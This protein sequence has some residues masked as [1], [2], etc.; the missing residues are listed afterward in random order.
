MKPVV[1]KHHQHK[2]NGPARSLSGSRQML[3]TAL[4]F[5][6][7]STL[8]TGAWAAQHQQFLALG[9]GNLEGFNDPT[10]DVYLVIPLTLQNS[11]TTGPAASSQADERYIGGDIAWSAKNSVFNSLTVYFGADYD[12]MSQSATAVNR[13]ITLTN[14][15]L[16]IESVTGNLN[17]VNFNETTNTVNN[18]DALLTFSALSINVKGCQ[19]GGDASSSVIFA[20]GGGSTDTS[21]SGDSSNRITDAAFSVSQSNYGS[22]QVLNAGSS[23]GA[24]GSSSSSRPVYSNTAFSFTGNTLSGT[25]GV[26]MV[27]TFTNSTTIEIND[28]DG[29]GGSSSASAPQPI[30]SFIV[31]GTIESS[32]QLHIRNVSLPLGAQIGINFSDCHFEDDTGACLLWIEGCALQSPVDGGA[33]AASLTVGTDDGISSDG[34][35]IIVDGNFASSSSSPSTAAAMITMGL[36][37]GGFVSI[38]NN[39]LLRP[40][41]TL[42]NFIG[43]IEMWGNDFGGS[44][45][46]DADYPATAATVEVRNEETETSAIPTSVLLGVN[47]GAALFTFRYVEA[48]SSIVMAR[49]EIGCTHVE[50]SSG[51][52]AYTT[53]DTTIVPALSMCNGVLAAL[54]SSSSPSSSSTTT[55]NADT[56][57]LTHLGIPRCT[58]TSPAAIP[59]FLPRVDRSDRIRVES[60]FEA[61]MGPD[62]VMTNATTTSTTEANT[63][64]TSLVTTT[65]T[66]AGDNTTNTSTV[67][68]TTTFVTN[69]TTFTDNATTTES[70]NA[71]TDDNATTII[72][73]VTNATTT[74]EVDNSTTMT[75]EEN[76]TTADDSNVTGNATTTLDIT[77]E[78]ET[79]T[80]N[81]SG[82]A[83]IITTDPIIAENATTTDEVDPSISF[84]NAT[85]TTSHNNTH[86]TSV[87]PPLSTT[88]SA[89]TI[90]TA[91]TMLP[92]NTSTTVPPLASST[93]GA[94][95]IITTSQKVDDENHDGGGDDGLNVGIIVAIIVVVCLFIVLIAVAIYWSYC[96]KP[97]SKADEP[98]EEIRSATEVGAAVVARQGRGGGNQASPNSTLVANRNSNNGRGSNSRNVYAIGQ[99]DFERNNQHFNAEGNGNTLPSGMPRPGT[100]NFDENGGQ[101]NRN[102]REM[103]AI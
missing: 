57:T 98:Y 86:N 89:T 35:I 22:M 18:N 101:L 39:Q 76:A 84:S 23:A 6:A 66:T 90:T 102:T 50:V 64:T 16:N 56:D 19:G 58:V 53:A 10:A 42:Y 95:P 65:N 78:T 67:D 2:N 8:T 21:N 99:S 88:I 27:G 31:Y 77:N 71:T 60:C 13:T 4:L 40:L 33:A 7:A 62:V 93:T 61:A 91:T 25:S 94:P 54:G 97:R 24:S 3:F 51:G 36:T 59:Q 20:L 11:S 100:Y 37:A 48:F 75:E 68:N 63:T 43:N 29:G 38:L 80:T 9:D 12:V 46:T 74:T 85:T 70:I 55:T 45:S 47:R 81:S 73:N 52:G 83:T 17:F 79:N 69:E 87:P 49:V 28:S 5:A 34:A 82:N 92:S 96:R 30:P 14:I 41:L 32:A 103:H 72:A 44:G 26:F 1:L 15:S